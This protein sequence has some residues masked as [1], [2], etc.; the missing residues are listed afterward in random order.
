MINAVPAIWAFSALMIDLFGVVCLVGLIFFVLF[1]VL[2][3]AAFVIR[4]VIQFIR[5]KVK[6]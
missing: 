6:S 5:V 2:L 3:F 4:H 1:W